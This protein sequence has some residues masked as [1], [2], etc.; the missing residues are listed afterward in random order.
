M[1]TA[2]VTKEPFTYCFCQESYAIDI[3]HLCPH[4]VRLSR[5]MH[6]NI[7]IYSQLALCKRKLYQQNSLPYNLE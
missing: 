1:Y 5:M 6:R 3:L 7:G 2:P 4:S